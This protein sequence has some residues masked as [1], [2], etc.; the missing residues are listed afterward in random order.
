MSV[1]DIRRK[2]ERRCALKNRLIQ[3]PVI[4]E[5]KFDAVG[6]ILISH[7]QPPPPPPPT[8]IKKLSPPIMWLDL[9]WCGLEKFITTVIVVCTCLPFPPQEFSLRKVAFGIADDFG[10]ACEEGSGG[11]PGSHSRPV[12]P[13][14]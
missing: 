8:T 7:L 4:G 13:R 11:L 6:D 2:A 10:G 5:I 3:V 9:S 1:N 14:D 12:D